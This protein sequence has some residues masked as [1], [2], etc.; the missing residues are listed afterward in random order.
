MDLHNNIPTRRKLT[1]GWNLE[2]FW[3]GIRVRF[4]R[5]SRDHHAPAISR[6]RKIVACRIWKWPPWRKPGRAGSFRQ[7]TPGL[8]NVLTTRSWDWF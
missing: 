2:P 7:S 8:S 6:R 3:R 4:A 1:W 5:R